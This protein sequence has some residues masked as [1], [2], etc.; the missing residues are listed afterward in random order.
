MSEA[1]ASYTKDRA[2]DLST[3]TKINNLTLYKRGLNLRAAVYG[4]LFPGVEAPGNPDPFDF[5]GASLWIS[6]DITGNAV[7]MSRLVVDSDAGLPSEN[8]LAPLIAARRERGERFAEFGRLINTSGDARAI[9]LH[10]AQIYYEGQRLGIETILMVAP[11]AKR[12]LYVRHFGAELLSANIGNDYGS[13]IIFAVY[14]WQLAKTKNPF[15]KWT[16]ITN[17]GI[18]GVRL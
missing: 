17:Q 5:F 2:P 3:I 15:F 11:L 10:Y 13:G 9:K 18:N 1:Q 12:R 4:R 8:V 16:G 6:T 14:A 7:S